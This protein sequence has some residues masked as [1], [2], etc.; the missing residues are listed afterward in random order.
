MNNMKR[1]HRF[2][3]VAFVLLA[4]TLSSCTTSQKQ[5]K[6]NQNNP[7]YNDWKYEEIKDGQIEI[8]AY[9]GKSESVIIPETIDGLRV[10]SLGKESFLHNKTVIH[11]VMPDSLESIGD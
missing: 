11:I 9:N 7:S 8:T 10:I 4:I 6:L 5:A 1:K 3:I 2:L